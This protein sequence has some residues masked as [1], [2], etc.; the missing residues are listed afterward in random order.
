MTAV[1]ALLGGRVTLRRRSGERVVA[2]EEFF[3]GPLES[4]VEPG[5]VAIEAIFPAPPPRTGSAWTE[6]ARRHGDYA[7]CGIGALVTLDADERVE[8]ARV[9]LIS[10]G[11][12]PVVVDVSE[13]VAGQRHD[14]IDA[15]AAGRLVMDMVDP[16]PDIHATAEYRRVLAGTLTSRAVGTAAVRAMERPR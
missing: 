1:L 9:G 5:E 14:S 12:T 16:D 11:P 8:S 13:A 2:A 15:A 4:A 6:V 10:V 3:L 7:V